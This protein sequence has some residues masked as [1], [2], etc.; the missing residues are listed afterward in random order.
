M[1]SLRL[2]EHF[3]ALIAKILKV[4]VAVPINTESSRM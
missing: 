2:M 4:M 1:A 3:F